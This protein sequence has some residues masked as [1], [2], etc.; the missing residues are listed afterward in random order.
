MPILHGFMS[1]LHPPLAAWSA[2]TP[3]RAPQVLL[4]FPC[5]LFSAVLAGRWA[6]G[7]A[8]LTPWMRGYW[9]RLLTAAAA[10]T[11]VTP[12]WNQ[13]NSVRALER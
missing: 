4:E 8:P 9:L 5:E 11:L 3:A 13:S 12:I 6:A 7:A 1:L 2:V 10:T